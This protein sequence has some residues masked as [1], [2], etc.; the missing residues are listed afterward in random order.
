MKKKKKKFMA[1]MRKSLSVYE[2]GAL[3]GPSFRHLVERQREGGGRGRGNEQ[4][5]PGPEFD[6][7]T[8]RT[9]RR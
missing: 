5:C 1:L 2:G 3:P 9:A 6:A 8:P 4:R 7:E